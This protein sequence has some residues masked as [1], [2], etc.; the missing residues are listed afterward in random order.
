MNPSYFRIRLP[1]PEAKQRLANWLGIDGIHDLVV[2]DPLN[3]VRLAC[4]P[5]GSW[6]GPALFL[7][8][9]EHWSVFEDLTGRFSAQPGSAW[10][11]FAKTDD[12][13][14]AGYNDA[15]LSAE[16]VVISG[17]QLVREFSRDRKNPETDVDAGALPF[18]SSSPL[19]SWLDV[20]SF[21]D[22][23]R[24]YGNDEG[25]LWVSDSETAGYTG[26][27]SH[28]PGSSRSKAGAAR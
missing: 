22:D 10:L 20:A 12:F 6:R 17:G 21:V 27:R 14:F 28:G 23:D 25:W 3:A 19:R 9:K 2:T 11:S 26:D 8:E 1:L 18:E 16:L 4:T 13:V 15:T 24:L 5:H 7:Y